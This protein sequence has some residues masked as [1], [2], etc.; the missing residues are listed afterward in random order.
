MLGVE[1]VETRRDDELAR[2]S[3]TTVTAPPLLRRRTVLG[4]LGAVAAVLALD[5][6]HGVALADDKKKL[7][8]VEAHPQ[9]TTLFF[10]L[11]NAPFADD[12]KYN[13]ATVL[14]FVPAYY[15]LPKSRAVDMVVHFHGHISTAERAVYGHS[16]REQLADSKQNAIL[17]APQGPVMTPD[18]SAGKLEKSGGFKRLVRELIKELRRA[19][20]G[21]ALGDSSLAGAYDAGIVCLSGHSGGY[22]AVAHCLERGS[23]EVREVYLFDALYGR[24]STFRSWVLAEQEK[25]GRHKLMDFYAGGDPTTNSLKLLEQLKAD[26]IRCYHEQTAG[27]L[28]RAQMTKGQAVFIH[29]PLAHSEA[30]FRHNAMRDCLYASSL[31]RYVKSDWFEAKNKPRQIDRR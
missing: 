27:E 8:R 19:D 14:V 22:N 24:V 1:A 30:T 9:G 31:K 23:V 11:D 2:G 26:G 28:T 13:D 16:L 25:P 10:A 5:L 29:T 4:I 21:A 12:G 3:W 7:K 18:S 15:R 17:V 20:V 6:G